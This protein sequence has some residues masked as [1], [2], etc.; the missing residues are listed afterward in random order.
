MNVVEVRK[1]AADARNKMDAEA[2]ARRAA[3][4]TANEDAY[5]VYKDANRSFLKAQIED[6]INEAATLRGDT[7]VSITQSQKDNLKI[8][9]HY[10]RLMNELADELR[11]DGFTVKA[12]ESKDWSRGYG[13]RISWA[14]DG[15]AE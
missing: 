2:E 6:K 5:I 11:N 7:D 10:V 9:N 8:W 15:P 13:I 3:A 1:R 12:S 14:E 4:H